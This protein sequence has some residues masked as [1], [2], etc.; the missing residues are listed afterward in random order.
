MYVPISNCKQDL[1]NV[2]S[3]R[4]DTGANLLD[5]NLQPKAVFSG[6]ANSDLCFIIADSFENNPQI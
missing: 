2:A 4:S 3:S 1:K 6:V 5:L